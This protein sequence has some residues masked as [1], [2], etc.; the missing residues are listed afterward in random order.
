ML[1]TRGA[2]MAAQVPFPKTPSSS[3]SLKPAGG[4]EAITV[5]NLDVEAGRGWEMNYKLTEHR[6]VMVGLRNYTEVTTGRM[7][8]T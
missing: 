1:R 8:S 4:E 7:V 2:S 5:Y 3:G 6:R